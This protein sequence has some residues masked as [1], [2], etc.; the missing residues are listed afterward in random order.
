MFGVELAPHDAKRRCIDLGQRRLTHHFAKELPVHQNLHRHLVADFVQNPVGLANSPARQAVGGRGQSDHPQVGVDLLEVGDELA[1]HP[2][3]ADQMRFIDDHQIEIAE[4]GR[5]IVDGL[6]PRDDDRGIGFPTF[7]TRGVNPDAHRGAN[8]LELVGALLQKLFHMGED[9]HSP[10]PRGDRV[11]AER[12]DHRRLAAG[13]RNH[14]ARVR[15]PVAKMIVY[16]VH[17]GLLVVA[18]DH[19]IGSENPRPRAPGLKGGTTTCASTAGQNLAAV[20][21]LAVSER[22]PNR[23]T[24]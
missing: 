22:R 23:W 19:G 10:I 4:Q 21:P 15:R 1:V 6:D 18:E 13:R 3:F 11:A 17:G 7:Q 2:F 24:G 16:G 8:S 9:Q 5:F 20:G 12:G 14:D